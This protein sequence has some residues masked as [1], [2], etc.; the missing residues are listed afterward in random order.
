[1]LGVDG[2]QPLGL[3]LD[4]IHDE[5]AAHDERL[6]VRER[7]RLPV[8]QRSERGPESGRADERVQ[9][10]VRIGLRR[11][12]LRGIGPD[13]ELHPSDG[14]ETG[15]DLLGGVLVRDPHDRRKELTDLPGE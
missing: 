11:E 6:L 13:D 9:D 3:P 4:Q 15:P 2:E 7:E 10:D 1:V 8:L 14:T 12:P 5:F